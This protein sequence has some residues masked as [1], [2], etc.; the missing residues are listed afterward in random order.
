MKK[1]TKK[2]SPKKQIAKKVIA[3]VITHK[4]QDPEPETEEEFGEDSTETNESA[5][6]ADPESIG[7]Y[8]MTE[9]EPIHSSQF[10]EE[11]P[12]P[13]ETL[14]IPQRSYLQGLF[15]SLSNDI[16][17]LPKEDAI[18]AISRATSRE[19]GQIQFLISQAQ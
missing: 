2:P 3:K 9:G 5:E 6:L 1:Q 10:A 11:P 16:L 12:Q 4:K 15:P 13:Y 14:T 8:K 19:L 7:E 17:S 18:K